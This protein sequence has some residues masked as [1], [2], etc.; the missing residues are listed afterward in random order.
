MSIRRSRV[1]FRPCRRHRQRYL[2]IAKCIYQIAAPV[3]DP[4]LC[5]CLLIHTRGT[6]L[7]FRSSRFSTSSS[8][9]PCQV[10]IWSK[11]PVR[12]DLKGPV[13]FPDSILILRAPC[14]F[15]FFSDSIRSEGPH[16]VSWASKRRFFS[17]ACSS[18]ERMWRK[19][20]FYY[21]WK[22]RRTEVWFARCV[23]LIRILLG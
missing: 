4:A 23:I 9:T 16:A 7:C 5:V 8:S 15:R 2:R 18:E 6:I 17:D 13:R 3:I 12:F 14:G 1:P 10:P 20:I 19:P 21:F 11:G 22:K